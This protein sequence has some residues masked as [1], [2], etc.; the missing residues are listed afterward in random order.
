MTEASRVFIDTNILVY[1]YNLDNPVKRKRARDLLQND[2]TD[3]EL[4]ISVQVLNEYYVSLSKEKY[5]ISHKK[6]AAFI[7][8][9]IRCSTVCALQIQTV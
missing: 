7:S 4:V 2:L 9:I 3:K 6:I 8:D 1:A 5:H